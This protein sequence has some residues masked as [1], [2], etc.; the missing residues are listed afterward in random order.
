MRNSSS[1]LLVLALSCPVLVGCG[2]NQPSLVEVTGVVN[3]QGKPLTGGCIVF[4]PNPEK[5][6]RGPL[7][8]AAI[9]PDGTYCLR[10]GDAVGAVPG[11]HRIT[12]SDAEPAP[13][14]GEGEFVAVHSM[15]PARYAAPDLSGLEANVQR[16]AKCLVDISLE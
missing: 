16:G 15:V 13:P 1:I 10:T 6:G 3:Y 7:A 12:I 4:A 8:V 9:Q 11:W 14:V 5:G 2:G